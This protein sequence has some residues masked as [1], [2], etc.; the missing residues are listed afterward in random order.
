MTTPRAYHMAVKLSD[1]RVLVSGGYTQ[2]NDPESGPHPEVQ[3]FGIVATAELYDPASGIWSATGSMAVARVGHQAVLLD[4]GKVLVA[5][6]RAGSATRTASAELFNPT[7]GTWSTTGS[8]AVARFRHTLTLL[9]DGRVLVAGGASNARAEVYDPATGKWSSAG[10]LSVA[11]LEH[12][13]TLLGDGRVMVVGGANGTATNGLAS[14]E[15]FDPTTRTWSP[16]ASMGTLRYRHSA[17]RLASG[18]MLVAGGV[19]LMSAEVYDPAAGAWSPTGSLLV[20]HADS[21]D[22]DDKA[23]LLA[24]GR[25]L[26]AG[27]DGYWET[28]ESSSGSMA[29]LYDP[30]TGIWTLTSRMVRVLNGHTLTQLSDGRV[31]NAGGYDVSCGFRYCGLF[32]TRPWAFAELYDLAALGNEPPTLHNGPEPSLVINKRLQQTTQGYTQGIP[33]KLSWG[34]ASDPDGIAGYSIPK[35][36]PGKYK[37]CGSSFP[38]H[39]TSTIC[40]HPWSQGDRYWQYAAHATDTL[41]EV[42]NRALG[43]AFNLQLSEESSDEIVDTGSWTTAPLSGAS[44]GSVQHASTSGSKATFTFTGRGVAWASTT[45]PNRGKA[46]I[47]LDGV[48]VKTVD[49]YA[50]STTT[51]KI[52]FVANDLA[53]TS[54]TLEVRILGTKHPKSTSNR[55]DVDAFAVLY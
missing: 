12:T 54:H 27:G 7:T 48:K 15:L 13:A 4:N 38:G 19:G 31:L 35:V 25:V 17:T 39:V 16:A 5:G 21:I 40:T 29:E 37:V 42:S 20:N 36:S 41:G 52:V 43:P 45:A 33:V 11:R 2:G 8:M 3:L 51:R 47:W 34:P 49:L 26:V 44:D 9:A 10:N 23:V 1:G 32:D 14:A 30:V 22:A 46:E 6:G 28:W 18:M 50:S 55:V 53:D 24:D